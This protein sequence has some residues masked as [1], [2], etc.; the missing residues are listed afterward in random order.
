VKIAAKAGAKFK[1]CSRSSISPMRAAIPRLRASR[2][3]HCIR[4]RTELGLIRSSRLVRTT[5]VPVL[6]VRGTKAPPKD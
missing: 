3:S 5:R 4:A 1:L 2:F 6:L